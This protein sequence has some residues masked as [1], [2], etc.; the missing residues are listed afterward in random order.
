[1]KGGFPARYL[2]FYFLRSFFFLIQQHLILNKQCGMNSVSLQPWCVCLQPTST[3]SLWRIPINQSSVLFFR[4]SN[5]IRASLKMLEDYGKKKT[6]EM[7]RL[8]KRFD[9]CWEC[10]FFFLSGD[11][12]SGLNTANGLKG[13]WWWHHFILGKRK[14]TDRDQAGDGG[15]DGQPYH[16]PQF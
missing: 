12:S 9:G 4:S 14:S 3:N 8:L 1:M 11:K 5:I 2:F 16:L 6:G 15:S 7:R 10:F 13:E